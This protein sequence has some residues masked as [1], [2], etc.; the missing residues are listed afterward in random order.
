MRLDYVSRDLAKVVNE[1][2]VS[3]NGCYSVFI[4]IIDSFF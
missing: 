2:F 4:I 3:L 1:D